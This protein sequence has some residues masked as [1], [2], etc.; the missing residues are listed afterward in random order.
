MFTFVQSKSKSMETTTHV[1]R[2]TKGE[3]TI[4]EIMDVMD[5]AIKNEPRPF[6]HMTVKVTAEAISVTLEA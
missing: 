3:P 1:K 2:T 4:E 5:E 6:R